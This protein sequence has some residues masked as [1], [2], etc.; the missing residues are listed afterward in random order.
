MCSRDRPRC[1]LLN[2][3]SAKAVRQRNGGGRGGWGRSR[4][5]REAT[6]G[7]TVKVALGCFHFVRKPLH[8]NQT[9]TPPTLHAH[10]RGIYIKYSLSHSLCVLG[11]FVS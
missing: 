11:R 9:P 2:V 4:K 5:S 8:L 3:D 10:V 7:C 6:K 1:W